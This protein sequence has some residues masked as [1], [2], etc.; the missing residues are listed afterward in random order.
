[1]PARSYRVQ[2]KPRKTTRNTHTR[3]DV[4]NVASDG[5]SLSI[6][7]TKRRSISLSSGPDLADIPAYQSDDANADK[8]SQSPENRDRPY[9]DRRELCPIS[10]NETNLNN[11]R[12]KSRRS[13]QQSDRQGRMP[14]F[15]SYD[16]EPSLLPL[17]KRYPAINPEYF[18][19]IFDN[20]FK[21]ENLA[22]LSNDF[23]TS[24]RSTKKDIIEG[25]AI[26]TVNIE[27]DAV[28]ED[29]KDMA[30]LSKCFEV[31]T[32]ALVFVS[33]IAQPSRNRRLRLKAALKD[34]LWFVSNVNMRIVDKFEGQ[35]SNHFMFH[36]KRAILGVD[37]PTGW[38]SPDKVLISQCLQKQMQLLA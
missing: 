31:Y 29:I 33:S 34:H 35:R 3:E 7:Q 13:P 38:E 12:V 20:R 25:G 6:S 15:Y 10:G 36:K 4:I 16:I 23:L 30:H 21:P 26:R 32:E 14:S 28:P 27:D 37:D 18:Q 8:I 22:K 19:E 1:M 9:Q 17:T 24:C 2:K 11:G 5:Q